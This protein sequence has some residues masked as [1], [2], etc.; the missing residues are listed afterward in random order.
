MQLTDNDAT[1]DLPANLA[2]AF[3]PP[4]DIAAEDAP[5]RNLKNPSGEP[6]RGLNQVPVIAHGQMFEQ[7]DEILSKTDLPVR[8][9]LNIRSAV[10]A[11]L[12][13]MSAEIASRI[14]AG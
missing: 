10:Q 12:D 3:V 1:R 14:R 7:V 11:E 4:V 13:K 5:A 2:N 6:A 9:V 8:T